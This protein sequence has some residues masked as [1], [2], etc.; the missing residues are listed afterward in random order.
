VEGEKK[1]KKFLDI[2][3]LMYSFKGDNGKK[4]PTLSVHESCTLKFSPENEKTKE[5][6]KKF[7]YPRPF[8]HQSYQSF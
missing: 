4:C 7:F 5:I 3:A 2:L 1:E 6:M 8:S